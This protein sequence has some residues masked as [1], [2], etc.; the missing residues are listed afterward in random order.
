MQQISHWTNSMRKS[1]YIDVSAQTRNLPPKKK[2]PH[3][4]F[5]DIVPVREDKMKTRPVMRIS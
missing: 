5:S 2:L 4:N 1:F 3:F